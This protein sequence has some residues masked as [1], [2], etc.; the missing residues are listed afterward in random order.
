MESVVLD[1]DVASRSIRGDLPPEVV[2]SLQGNSILLTFV[3]VGELL[4]GAIHARWG[5]RR[6][7]ELQ[8][9]I[10]R[11]PQLDSDPGVSETWGRLV[12]ARDHAGNP[13][14]PNDAWIAACC[15]TAEL[16]L[17]TFNRKHFEGIEDLD[18]FLQ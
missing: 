16:P 3:T 9:W 2:R 5:P 11:Y 8:E 13:I 7:G 6:M 10:A 12:A 14:N 18:L 4:N 17:A 15:I 1:T